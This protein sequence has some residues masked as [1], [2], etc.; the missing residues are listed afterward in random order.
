MGKTFSIL[1]FLFILILASF[2]RLYH[3]KDNPAGFFCDEASIGY[4]AYSILTTSRDEWGKKFPLFFKAF[5]EYKNPVMTY[6]SIPFIWFFG[7]NEFSVRLTSVFY[8][9][10]SLFAIYFLSS[11]LFNPQIALIS[12]LFLAISPWHIHFSRV[13][14]EG[15]T[16]FVFFTTL[17]TYF[18]V[19]FIHRPNSLF[20]P[21]I[22]I[23]I[24]SLALYSYFPARIFL[25]LYCLSLVL[26]S[27]RRLLSQPRR[28]FFLFLLTTSLLLPLLDHLING[29]G[30]S[31]WHQIK[32]DVSFSTI[33]QK[34]PQ[35]FSFAF[36]FSKG[37]IDFPGQ[38]IARH[39][40]RGVGEL[41]YFQLPLLLIS[42][43]FISKYPILIFWLIAYPFCDLFTDSLGPQAT[44]SVIGVIPFQILSAAALYYL[45]KKLPKITVFLS[46]L[47][48]AYSV[49]NYFSKYKTYPLYSSDFWGW[50]YGPRPI[51]AYFLKNHPSYDQLC[52]EGKFNA[53]EIF[54]KF[55]DPRNSCQGKCQICDPTIYN[56]RQH[57]LF[58]VS[59]DSYDKLLS[60][61]Q[62]FKILHSITYPNHEIAFYIGQIY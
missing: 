34:Y 6:S 15:L 36:L 28:F 46:L 52:L 8:G 54:L 22:S 26:F 14:L 5:G 13:C 7:L 29:G 62:S 19:K 43:F 30:F 27:A 61:S 25:P 17:A 39:S 9:L 11:V 35:Y 48:I 60:S 16:P 53:P 4:N 42:L 12:S 2:L 47:I 40:I 56:P 44:R 31:R 41:F 10:L 45:F 18:W 59:K 3:L 49:L 50:Q 51:M 24:F 58:A 23:L 38:F 37:D 55:Y 20:F 33:I 21:S 57:Q 1:S 32:G